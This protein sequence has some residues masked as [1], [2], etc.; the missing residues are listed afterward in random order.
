MCPNAKKKGLL[1]RKAVAPEPDAKVALV[2]DAEGNPVLVMDSSGFVHS[3]EDEVRAWL[4]LPLLAL[5]PS[6]VL[7]WQLRSRHQCGICDR[8]CLLM[9][10]R[11]T[12]STAGTP[13]ARACHGAAV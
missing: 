13:R 5:P 8:S 4:L 12:G 3:A 6:A 9:M 10:C 7:L 11:V 2:R 1:P